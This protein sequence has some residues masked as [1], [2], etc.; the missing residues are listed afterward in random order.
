MDVTTDKAVTERT[1]GVC[2]NISAYCLNDIFN[3]F[4]TVTF[5]AFPFLCVASAF[6]GNR[7]ATN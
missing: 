7:L 4:R 6:V 3:E 5:D 1:H 2:Q